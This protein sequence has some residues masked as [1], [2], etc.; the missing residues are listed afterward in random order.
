MSADRLSRWSDDAREITLRKRQGRLTGNSRRLLLERMRS[1]ELL[2]RHI[3]NG[4]RVF[5]YRMLVGLAAGWMRGC[6][7]GA[8]LGRI[9]DV[10]LHGLV[11]MD[12]DMLVLL[13]CRPG[14]LC[15]ERDLA[16]H[17]KLAALA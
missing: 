17:L 11:L 1:H 7:K 10:D 12:V 6:G 5:L 9:P 3:W 14:L 2:G 8:V 4:C 13:I 16:V 15:T